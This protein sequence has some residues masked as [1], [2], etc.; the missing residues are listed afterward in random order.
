MLPRNITLA[1]CG[2]GTFSPGKDWKLLLSVIDLRGWPHF[3]VS[4]DHILSTADFSFEAITVT[5]LSTSK[6][7]VDH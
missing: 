6:T 7:G 5:L 1:S 4:T 3:Q 2:T